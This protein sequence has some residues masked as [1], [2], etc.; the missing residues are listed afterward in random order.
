MSKK[1]NCFKIGLRYKYAPETFY[2][3]SHMSFNCKVRISLSDSL[4]EKYQTS[5]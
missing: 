1:I 5:F 3:M 2:I 4:T